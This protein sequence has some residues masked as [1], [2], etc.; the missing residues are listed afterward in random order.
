MDFL[1]FKGPSVWTLPTKSV[2]APIPNGAIVLYRSE[3]S[4]LSIDLPY[5]LIDS[6]HCEG[7]ESPDYTGYQAH[8]LPKH[9][10]NWVNLTRVITNNWS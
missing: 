2:E 5:K 10:Q 6:L 7:K 4:M 9:L 1:H 3:W 8:K